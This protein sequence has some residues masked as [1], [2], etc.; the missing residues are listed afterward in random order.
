LSRRERGGA[1]AGVVVSEGLGGY[2]FDDQAA[3]RAGAVRDGNTYAGTPLTPGF[4]QVREPAEAVSIQLVLDD[5][6]VA[7]GDCT[8]VQ[9]TG[10]G[11]RE[12]RFHAA[13]LAAAIA[14][15][16]APALVGLDVR[17][18]RE[19]SAAA[20]TL[21]GAAGL[22]RAA[23]YGLSQ[24][25]LAAAAHA[26]GHQL[27]AR[28]IQDEWSLSGPLQRV[29]VYAQTGDDRRANAD[30]MIL[31][32]V[33]VLPHG[34]INTPALVGADGGALVGYVEWLV[35]R[36]R[37]LRPDG[38]H[39]PVIHLDVYGQIGAVADGDVGRCADILQR[40]ERAAAPHR[41]RVEHPIHASGREEQIAALGELR[42]LLRSRGSTVQ[43][44]ADEWANTAE[45]IHRFA[46][47]GAADLVQIK[48]PDLGALHHT[49]DA[50]LD[51]RAHG[52]GAMLGGSCAETELSAR[53]TTHIGLATGVTQ[54]LAKP[55]MGVDEGLMIVTNE[56]NRALALDRHLP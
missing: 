54:M 17:C 13:E 36:I 27:M 34:L 41:L 10:V 4:A 45:D 18:F 25:L 2:F 5:G 23:A 3:I 44:V 51:C 9:Y 6:H 24:A 32:G 53:A 12:P 37:E 30:K 11:G 48:T 16:L 20:E 7:C 8:G 46:V 50:I 19:A 26:A 35:G 22:G 55:G 52:V 38:G 40:L 39:R 14:R 28:V 49:V 31:K 1:V 47:A 42:A 33:E 21:A 43:L 15:D 56:M 29:P